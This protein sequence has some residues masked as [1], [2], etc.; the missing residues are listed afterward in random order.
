MEDAHEILKETGDTASREARAARKR[1][2]AALESAK[3]Y[4]KN[5]EGKAVAGAKATDKAVRAHPY[6]AAGLA[7]GVGVLVGYL[8]K[9]KNTK[10]T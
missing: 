8:L 1:L 5:L 9:H 10:A 7:L 2:E 4:C 3:V 6:Q